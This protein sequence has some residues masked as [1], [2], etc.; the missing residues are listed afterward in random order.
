MIRRHLFLLGVLALLT[1]AVTSFLSP[2]FGAMELKFALRGPLQ[3]DSSIVLV[4]IDEAAVRAL[5]WPVRRN[6]YSL[7]IKAL[8]DLRARAVGVEVLFED[9]QNDFPEYDELLGNVI[10]SSKTVVLPCYFERVGGPAS[11][12]VPDSSGNPFR[13]PGVRREACANAAGLHLPLRLLLRN[14]AGTGHTPARATFPSSCKPE[15][16][17]SLHSLWKSSESRSGRSARR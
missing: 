1:G 17:P 9:P 5:G 11:P 2:P 3:P 12:A 4:Y 8:A 15:I 6:F 13:F 7:M 14:A 10:R 16:G